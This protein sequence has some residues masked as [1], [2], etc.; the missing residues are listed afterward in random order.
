MKDIFSVFGAKEKNRV[1]VLALCLFLS[2]VVLFLVSFRERRSYGNLVGELEARKKQF[3]TLDKERRAAS[4][5]AARW[6]KAAQ[7]LDVEMPH[8][9]SSAGCLTRHG[10]R[11]W[12]NVIEGFPALK[13]PP[14]FFGLV[15]QLG[16]RKISDFRFQRIHM[17]YQ[18]PH[19]LELTLVLR[20]KNLAQYCSNHNLY[21][22]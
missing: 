16:I 7:D 8:V 3:A 19:P 18:R 17:L 12:Q 9:Q 4:N 14:Q 10:E 13:P 15:F 5:E 20:A 1:R 11:L 6:E 21:N 22:R 2:L